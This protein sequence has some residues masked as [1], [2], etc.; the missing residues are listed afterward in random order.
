MR[1]SKVRND[2]IMLPLELKKWFGNS[3]VVDENG[4][5]MVVYHATTE[6]FSLFDTASFKSHFG[7]LAQAEA[8]MSELSSMGI[9]KQNGYDV[10][11]IPQ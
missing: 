2:N 10:K 6:N 11:M 4:K 1:I 9:N 3:K 7:T 8:R 5:P